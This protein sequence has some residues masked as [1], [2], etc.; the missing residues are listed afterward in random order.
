MVSVSPFSFK[1]VGGQKLTAYRPLTR[2][3]YP[4]ARA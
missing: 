3:K 2:R 1:T 4:I